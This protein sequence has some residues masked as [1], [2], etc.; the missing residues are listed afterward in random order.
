MMRLRSLK[1]GSQLLDPAAASYPLHSPSRGVRETTSSALA[2][3]SA[4]L[5]PTEAS[6]LASPDFYFMVCQLSETE[7]QLTISM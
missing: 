1:L 4:G 7:Q 5:A 2:P 6:T 3:A